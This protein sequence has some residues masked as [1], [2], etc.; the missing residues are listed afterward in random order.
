MTDTAITG[1]AEL[2]QG[3]MPGVTPMALHDRLAR[4]A[5][6][7]AGLSAGDVD[8]VITLSPR[9]DPYLIHATALAE[10][11]SIAPPVA[12]TIEGGGAAPA[13]M[14]DLPA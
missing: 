7:D 4:L 1:I 2:P 11:M 13:T 5:L 14:V 8:A 12:L 10:Y 6:H 3:R 9:S